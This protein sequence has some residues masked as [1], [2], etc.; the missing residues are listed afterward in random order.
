MAPAA[1]ISPTHGARLDDGIRGANGFPYIIGRAFRGLPDWPPPFDS[2]ENLLKA[3]PQLA[4]QCL[5]RDS[6]YVEWYRDML[7]TTQPD[8]VIYDTACWDNGDAPTDRMRALTA[9]GKRE[10]VVPL[11]PPGRQGKEE[12]RSGIELT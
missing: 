10:L 1:L 11:P 5:G 2:A 6:E 7:R 8:G 3:H 9:D 4:V 12:K